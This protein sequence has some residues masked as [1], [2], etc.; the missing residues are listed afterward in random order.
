MS[1][2]VWSIIKYKPKEGCE[3]EFVEALGRLGNMMSENKP[4]E[5]LNDFIGLIL[6]SLP[7]SRV[8]RTW[9]L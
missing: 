6:K 8:C 7:K 1:E 4:Y 9:M 5:F 3:D 2:V